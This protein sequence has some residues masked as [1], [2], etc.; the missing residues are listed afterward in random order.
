MKRDLLYKP[1]F[2]CILYLLLLAKDIAVGQTTVFNDAFTQT[3]ATVYHGSTLSSTTTYTAATTASLSASGNTGV[4]TFNLTGTGVAPNNQ[5]TITG[6]GTTNTKGSATLTGA[7]SA[8]ATPFNTTLSSNI[9]TI[10]WTFNMRNTRSGGTTLLSTAFVPGSSF[11]SAFILATN[12]ATN[13]TLTAASSNT[14]KGW[15]VTITRGSTTA[16]NKID[17]GYFTAGLNAT[18]NC[19]T[20]IISSGDYAAAT[21]YFSIK[22][23][24]NP[25]NNTWALFVR[26]DGTT[27]SVDPTTTATQIGTNTVEA[28]NTGIAMTNFM[29]YQTHGGTQ[30]TYLDNVK[31]VVG[32]GINTPSP[33]TLT[34]LNYTSGMGPSTEQSFT[35]NAPNL[36]GNLVITP[37]T[38]YEISTGTGGSFVPTNP[39]TISAASAIS[40]TTIYVR[41]KAGLTDGTYNESITLSSTNAPSKTIACS[42]T[43][44]STPSISLNTNSLSTFP[45]TAVGSSSSS[46]NFTIIGA[47]LGANNVTIT[48]P[49]NFELSLTSSSGFSTNPLVLTPMAGAIAT[50]TIYVRY[51]PTGSGSNTGNVTVSND[52]V[53]TQNVSVSGI[54]G[55]F[56]YK[57]GSLASISSWA[58][59]SDLTGDSPADFTTAGVSYVLLSSATTT[60]ASWTVSGLGSKVVV[61]DPSVSGITLTIALGKAINGTI[62]IPAASSSSNSLV[63]KETTTQPTLGT[64]HS[65]SEVHY[66]T[67]SNSLNLTATFGKL[68]IENNSNVSSGANSILS[69][70]TIQTSLTI[71]AG[72]T[73][74]YSSGS[75]PYLYFSTGATATINGTLKT[76]KLT[77]L[78]SFNVASASTSGALLQFQDSETPGVT[79]VLGSASTISFYKGNNGTAQTITARTDYANLKIEDNSSSGANNKITTGAITVAGILT[80]NL[81]NSGSAI[82]F[83]GDITVNGALNITGLSLPSYSNIILGSSVGVTFNGTIAQT[84]GATFPTTLASLTINNSAGV[85]LSNPTT[86]N[87]TLTF[88]TG[89]LSLGANDLTIASGGSISG[90]SSSNYIVTNGIGRL[91]FNNVSGAKTFPIGSSSSSYDP[92]TLTPTSATNLGVKV[93]SSF[94][95]AVLDGAKVTAREWDITSS[96]PSSTL[97]ALTHDATAVAPSGTAVMGHYTGGAWN[98]TDVIGATYNGVTR[99]YTGTCSTF[100]PFG[101]GVEGGF[102]AALSTEL[103]SFTAK[104]QPH[105]NLIE[106]TTATEQN[107][108]SFDIERS[109]NG[110]DF[111]S[112]G[113]VKGNGTTQNISRYTFTDEDLLS[114]GSSLNSISYY[115][116]RSVDFN[117]KSELSNVVTVVRSNKSSIK[118]Y[119]TVATDKLFVIASDSENRTFSIVN[120]L[121]VIVQQGVLTEQ[122]ELTIGQLAMGTY[123]LKVGNEIIKFVKH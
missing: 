78:T 12:A 123:W 25:S 50:T 72:S 66:N 93:S 9:G 2:L 52:L 6:T 4:A 84:T 32:E 106:W 28:T 63:I 15:A 114:T 40:N 3:A 11:S 88:T 39:I 81:V 23:T 92:A 17:L 82:T 67:F 27:A 120:L 79:L 99:T 56:Y 97:L 94:A 80:I 47:N 69:N 24:Y 95:N 46:N 51:T 87:G 42:G 58:A 20:S 112:L 59:K 55:K 75:N 60:D 14:T 109:T 19:F 85:T 108:A 57:G 101:G 96:T 35:V 116:L 64:L 76:A 121:G 38:N 22:V 117:G 110:R 45:S 5:L 105:G 48:P 89:K 34:G 115:R 10:T 13:A 26:D 113:Q 98:V 65:S 73:L 36:S 61:G 30:N 91:I 37:P 102:V 49:T 70:A 21:N 86:V 16:F 33:S 8:F 90:T 83:G 54:I 107:N 31:V 119:P 62:D 41:L 111:V 104:A 7:L 100:S 103:V 18:T 77:G 43:V 1:S 71:D 68:F 74:D 53:T 118:V 122:K 29:L 44:S